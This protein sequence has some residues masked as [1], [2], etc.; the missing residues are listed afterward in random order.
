MQMNNRIKIKVFDFLM[1]LGMWEF[2][3]HLLYMRIFDKPSKSFE[4]KM[5]EWRY[6][7]K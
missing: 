1:T 6:A 2:I 7:N 5:R 4:D 3:Y